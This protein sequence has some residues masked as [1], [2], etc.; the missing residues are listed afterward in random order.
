MHR[1]LT[2]VVVFSE[3][4]ADAGVMQG[5]SRDLAYRLAAQTMVRNSP[6]VKMKQGKL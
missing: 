5:L 1:Q 3:A 6:T 4:M 2:T